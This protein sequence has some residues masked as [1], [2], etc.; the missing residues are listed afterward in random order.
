MDIIGCGAY[1]LRLELLSCMWH[2]FANH[3][4][5]CFAYRRQFPAMSANPTARAN[6]AKNCV[7]LIQAYDFDGIDIDWGE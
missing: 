1:H 4:I 6:F 2:I 5:L 7:E 3:L